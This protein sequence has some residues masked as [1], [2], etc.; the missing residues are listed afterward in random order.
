MLQKIAR[1]I[2]NCAHEYTDMPFPT[3]L[4]LRNAVAYVTGRAATLIAR[5]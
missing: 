3:V 4:C 2:R 5:I 1:T